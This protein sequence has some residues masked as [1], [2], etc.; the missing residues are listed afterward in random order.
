MP[1]EFHDYSVQV[2]EAMDDAVVSFLH[3]AASELKSQAQRKTKV[4]KVSG[5]KTK[6]AW[7]YVVDEADLK[8]TVGNTEENAIWEEL[9]T[10]EYALEGKG[11]KGG[12]YILIGEGEGMISQRVVDAYGMTVKHGKDGKKY[13]YTTGK[14]PKRMLHNAFVENKA[15][16]IRRAETILKGRLD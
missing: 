8:A 7:D 4:G 1:V 10:G 16:I 11:R 6:G 9:G 5:G 3:E 12:W 14:K 13:A 2:R 15:K